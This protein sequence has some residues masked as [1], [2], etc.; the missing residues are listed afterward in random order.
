M[1]TVFRVSI[2][3]RFCIILA[4]VGILS[5]SIIAPVSPLSIDLPGDHPPNPGSDYPWTPANYTGVGDIQAAFT[6]VVPTRAGDS[7]P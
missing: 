7:R 2:N 6:M 4:I 3:F 5:L 1:S